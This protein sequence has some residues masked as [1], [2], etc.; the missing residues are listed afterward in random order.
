MKFLSIQAKAVA[1]ISILFLI[2]F[3][4]IIAF[5]VVSQRRR[6]LATTAQKLQNNTELLD[7][8][9]NSIMLAGQ[10]DI[11]NITIENL[12]KLGLFEE[13]R[14]YRRDG[15][16][17]FTQTE[18]GEAQKNAVMAD[19][20][21]QKAVSS[22]KPV[23][24]ELADAKELAYY[25]PVLN[26]QECQECHDS[27][28]SIRGVEYIRIS[29]LESFNENSQTTAM[30]TG[31]LAVIA[32]VGAIVFF[33]FLRKIII[34]PIFKLHDTVTK[35]K[36][37]D[38]TGKVKFQSNDELGMLSADISNFVDT[39][40]QI[41]SDI[42]HT[43]A[44]TKTVSV[45]LAAS[46]NAS[47]AAL[48]QIST[49]AE[50]VNDQIGSLDKEVADSNNSAVDV[51]KHI[52]IV[53]G[54][55]S[56]QSAAISQS[57]A[58]IEQMSASI[59]S[60]AKLAEDKLKRTSELEA[61]AISGE[62]EM[63]ETITAI[64]SVGE[65]TDSLLGMISVIENIASQTNL[66][67]MNAAIEAA[68]AGELGKGFAVVA[69]EVR[70]LA[71]S[72]SNSAREISVTLENVAENIRHAEAST[73]TTGSF[74]GTIMSGI[75]EVSDSMREMKEAT[76]ELA[77]GS[78]QIL[79][80]LTSLVSVTEKVKESGASMSN[81][82]NIITGSISNLRSISADT[83]NGMAEIVSRMGEISKAADD[84]SA[85]GVKNSDGVSEL[86]RV[87]SQF[88]VEE[89]PKGGSGTPIDDAGHSLL[90]ETGTT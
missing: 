85:N 55:I 43:T 79:A 32:A 7:S 18:S 90:D 46:S 24:V 80:S 52:A 29:F 6:L 62:S 3:S 5:T 23:K 1:I 14:I 61:N 10:A 50:S 49:N 25:F 22:E 45:S 15:S 38:L 68:H 82:V 47:A 41:I 36:S 28:E 54:L 20:N 26:K 2:T 44:S 76:H 9:L 11:M 63:E 72:S 74:F 12:Q 8:L 53:V 71:E 88:K 19:A 35:L 75:R 67:A 84:V 21:F 66:L 59:G 37:G 70:N 64:R 83:K 33:L 30:L 42:K 4:I 51:N 56:E 39:L 60:I 81:D 58:S 77:V 57:S 31:G 16:E 86:E 40:K 65:S 89:E 27:S 87:V 48:E 13:I 69:D 34:G 78:N 73:Q 17:A